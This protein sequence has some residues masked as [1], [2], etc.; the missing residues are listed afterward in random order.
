MMYLLVF[1]ALVFSSLIY[2][3]L[4]RKYNIVDKPNHRSLHE[5]NTLRGGGVLIVFATLIYFLIFPERTNV[6]F[7]ICILILGLISFLDDI[8]TLSSLLRFF[9]HFT[10]ISLLLWSCD[11]VFGINVYS[12]CLI[13]VFYIAS[14]GFLNIYNFMDGINGITFLNAFTSYLFLYIINSKVAAID[15]DLLIFLAFGLVIFGFYNFRKKAVLFGGDIGSITIG[16]S[17]LFFTISIFNKSNNP[18]VFMILYIY[19]IDGGWTIVKRFIAKE[20]IFK[21]HKNHLYQKL[22]TV[23]KWSHLK[24]SFIYFSIQTLLNSLIVLFWN[25]NFNKFYLSAMVFIILSIIYFFIS[26]QI[27]KYQVK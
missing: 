6:V 17:M 9:I 4:A 24:T 22:I 10:A 2:I 18:L 23:F 27:E 8:Y 16:F 25:T 14:L 21:P 26:N 13:A 19:L 1:I 11:Y 15:P 20:N 7:L 5:K 12:V 3:K